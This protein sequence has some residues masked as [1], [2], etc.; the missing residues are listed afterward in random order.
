MGLSICV[1][2]ADAADGFYVPAG[3]DAAS[4]D[5]SWWF[6][7]RRRCP[8]RQAVGWRHKGGIGKLRFND[9][10]QSHHHAHA[11]RAHA[12]ATCF[13]STIR[14]MVLRGWFPGRVRLRNIHALWNIAMSRGQTDKHR[15]CQQSGAQ[16]AQDIPAC[17]CFHDIPIPDRLTLTCPRLIALTCVK[18]AACRE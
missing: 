9:S 2:V 13:K 7:T 15:E 6:K 16:E 3:A 18:Q 17:H 8:A 12:A 11:C 4:S 5:R 14:L 10:A 1:G